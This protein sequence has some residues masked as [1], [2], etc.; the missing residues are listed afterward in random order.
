MIIEN[1]KQEHHR[2]GEIMFKS[3]EG[4]QATFGIT[5]ILVNNNKLK[6]EDDIDRV[7]G[8][9][10]IETHSMYRCDSL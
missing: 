10:V 8:D 9:M 6:Y 3:P 2:L 7:F 4:N 1:G 5:S